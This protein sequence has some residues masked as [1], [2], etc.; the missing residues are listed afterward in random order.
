MIWVSVDSKPLSLNV[1]LQSDDPL[2][3]IRKI[4]V[5]KVT[6]L[7]L[8]QISIKQDIAVLELNLGSSEKKCTLK[9][10]SLLN[11]IIKKL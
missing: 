8:F 5:I 7:L 10:S 9:Q 1:D 11:F 3:S 2:Y 6:E 4:F